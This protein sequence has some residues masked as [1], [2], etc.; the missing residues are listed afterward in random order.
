[1][2]GTMSLRI[3][4]LWQLVLATL[5]TLHAEVVYTDGSTS[6]THV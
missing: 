2:H 3:I 4:V 6:Y 1:M 5:M